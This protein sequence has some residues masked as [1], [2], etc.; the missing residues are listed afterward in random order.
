MKKFLC[1]PISFFSVSLSVLSLDSLV[2]SKQTPFDPDSKHSTLIKTVIVEPLPLAD[3]EFAAYLPGSNLIVCGPQGGTFHLTAPIDPSQK[4]A[5]YKQGYPLFITNSSD[6]NAKSFKTETRI[7]E[8]SNGRIIGILK[9]KQQT[10]YN[11]SPD[12]SCVEGPL[13][14]SVVVPESYP[15]TTIFADTP[16]AKDVTSTMIIQIKYNE[17]YGYRA[18]SKAVPAVPAS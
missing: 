4:L 18:F 3:A 10:H 11:F 2:E 15:P 7:E 6:A 5:T 8:S 12:Q 1:V 13:F 17:I 16:L 14:Y 9:A